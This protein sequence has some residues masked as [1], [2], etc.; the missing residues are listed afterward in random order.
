MARRLACF[1][2]DRGFPVSD[3]AITDLVQMHAKPLRRAAFLS[4]V[5]RTVAVDPAGLE[6]T[7]VLSE[8]SW[9]GWIVNRISPTSAALHD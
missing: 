5:C 2:R 7:V 9:A 4:V 6:Q 8:L 3:D 1:E